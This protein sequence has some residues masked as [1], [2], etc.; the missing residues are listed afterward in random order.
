MCFFHWNFMLYSWLL[1]VRLDIDHMIIQGDFFFHLLQK[2]KM[3]RTTTNVIKNMYL[4]SRVNSKR[5]KL[6]L[7]LRLKNQSDPETL[8]K[9]SKLQIFVKFSSPQW[10]HLNL[11]FFWTQNLC[12]YLFI[13]YMNT[14]CI[15]RSKK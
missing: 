8:P 14:F 11:N 13:L 3:H 15:T 12:I 5:K 4:E 9:V 10:I 1:Q 2:H 7:P 6:L